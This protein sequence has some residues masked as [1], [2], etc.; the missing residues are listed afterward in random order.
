[1]SLNRLQFLVLTAV[2]AAAR[3][4]PSVYYVRP[5]EWRSEEA[6]DS[7]IRSFRPYLEG[8]KIFLDPGHGGEDRVNRGPEG[9]VI[10]ADVNLRV[11]LEL[12][13]YLT[14]AG[15]V[16]FFSRTTDTT[17]PLRDRPLL[18]VH[19]GADIFLSL[20]HNATRDPITNFSSVYYHASQ[21]HPDYHPANHDLARYVQRDMSYAMRNP[22]PPSSETFNGTL[23]DFMIYPN[24]GFAVLRHNWL[25]AILVEGA[26]FTHPHEEQRLALDEFNRIEAWGIFIGVGRYF[27][28]GIPQL[29]LLSDSVTA[30]TQGSILVGITASRDIDPASI[31]ATLDGRP[32]DFRYDDSA[33][34]ISIV[35]DELIGGVH[36]FNAQVREKRGNASWPF[37][38]R[39]IV[40]LPAASLSIALDP[41]RIPKAGNALVR[42]RCTAEDKNGYPVVDGTPIRI[43]AGD[44]A[45]D[46]TIGTRNGIAWF[47]IPGLQAWEPVRLVSATTG[48]LITQTFLER[49]ISDNTY[50]TGRVFS[51]V[52]SLPL[53]GSSIVEFAD[54]S[55][56]LRLLDTTWND[57]RFIIFQEL[58]DRALLQIRRAGFFPRRLQLDDGPGPFE[59]DV[60]LDPVAHGRL[61]GKTLVIDPRY[62]GSESG[63]T[64]SAGRRSADI[65]LKVALRLHELLKAAGANATLIRTNDTTLAED[66]RARLSAMYPEGFYIRVDAS[67]RTEKAYC[68]IH[69]SIPNR[70][71]AAWL[72][73]GL[74]VSAG[75]DSAGI[76]APQELFFRNVALGTIS[77]TVP[78]VHTNYYDNDETYAVDRIAWGL[79]LGLLAS[80]G[81]VADLSDVY[82][83]TAGG[84]GEAIGGCTLILDDSF[85]TVT[86]ANGI[87][88][89][90]GLGSPQSTVRVIGNPSA[91]A[92]R[93]EGPVRSAE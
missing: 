61:I 6:I 15:A 3:C 77:V 92:K 40:K 11:G 93:L 9:D 49:S 28:D 60:A 65:N 59:K 31:D 47:Y 88:T 56:S 46:T 57:G 87:G 64:D 37:M 24:S 73:H 81:F 32:A 42:I 66:E 62:G 80:E 75:L 39:I 26:F 19:T 48:D 67:G 14:K 72:L 86:D 4:S 74:K 1:M 16:V 20:H 90:Y 82:C 53:S 36:E 38:R 68:S 17:I 25:P 91:A 7:V 63:D 83:V 76:S 33:R 55:S 50:I 21:G 10:E 51:T 12:G 23:S 52:D 78:S 44:G 35:H 43:T 29:R 45:L 41:W 85:T 79:F 70:K 8:K 58:P 13:E 5:R 69:S 22:G 30:D 89:F 54:T 27:R 18:A 34:V 71:L 84:T 2:L